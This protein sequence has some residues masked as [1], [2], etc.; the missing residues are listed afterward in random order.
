MTAEI[1]R[2]EIERLIREAKD[3][4]DLYIDIT[5]GEVHRNVGGYPGKNHN[6]PGCCDVMYSLKRSEDIILATPLKGKGASL[7]IRYIL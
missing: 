6:M 7:R 3:K 4:G 5:S 1:F 2:K